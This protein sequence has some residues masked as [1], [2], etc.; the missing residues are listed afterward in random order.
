MLD[1]ASAIWQTVR[2]LVL[3][4]R[5]RAELYPTN[6]L[7]TG[8][9]M[10]PRNFPTNERYTEDCPYVSLS[11]V[12]A[13]EYHVN[14]SLYKPSAVRVTLA[15]H[16]GEVITTHFSRMEIQKLVWALQDALKIINA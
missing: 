8:D 2:Q 4:I 13:S 7:L 15:S 14:V 16:D 5:R 10:K 12:V 6:H 9:E 11:D 1:K 3:P